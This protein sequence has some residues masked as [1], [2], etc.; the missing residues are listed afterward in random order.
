MSYTPQ[1]VFVYSAAQAG[2]MAGM[3]MPGTAAI[4]DQNT[5]DYDAL[6]RVA[7]AFAQEFDTQWGAIY[8]TNIY[9]EQAI[10]DA[11]LEY[12]QSRSPTPQNGLFI[13]DGFYL[14]DC[15]A[16]IALIRAGANFN[17]TNS[18]NLP[19]PGFGGATGATGATGPGAGATGATGATGI[20][21]PGTGATGATG[22]TGTTGITGVTGATGATGTG[23]GPHQLFIGGNTTFPAPANV[24]FVTAWGGGGGGGNGF[25]GNEGLLSSGGGGGGGGLIAST[26]PVVTT[27]GATLTA[28]IGGGG[29]AEVPGSV[30]SLSL[31]A[32]VLGL[33]MGGSAG[34]AGQ[35][36]DPDFSIVFALGGPPTTTSFGPQNGT[37]SVQVFPSAP[38]QGGCG[39]GS[40]VGINAL[41]A[42]GA[43]PGN[44]NVVTA[45]PNIV[46]SP[47][48]SVGGPAG[49]HGSSIPS[50]LAGGA[51]GGGGGGGP[52]GNGGSGGNGGNANLTTPTAG[53]NG[54]N[55]PNANSG[56][57]GG[58]GGAGG[59]GDSVGGAAGIGGTG[60]AGGMMVTWFA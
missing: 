36:G 25:A 42:Q 31:G 17:I 21:G 24:F 47:G 56:G 41:S 15:L 54:A 40:S 34:S 49:T 6:A 16:I 8:P 2:A 50:T 59:N 3:G 51:A 35:D 22:V 4:T 33:W 9:A 20:T 28:I 5:H 13:I 55:A 38:G 58:G 60:S 23:V 7:G 27:A 52:S 26:I 39:G 32:T 19:I 44:D 45:F 10:T 29:S 53:S 14:N 46:P 30:T 1:N 43:T 18:T 57:G 12:W 48:T 37:S 11:C